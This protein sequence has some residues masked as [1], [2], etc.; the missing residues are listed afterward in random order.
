MAECIIARGSNQQT[1]LSESGAAQIIV[2]PG[3]NTVVYCSNGAN[4]LT[5]ETSGEEVTFN[6]G[7]GSYYLYGNKVKPLSIRVDVEV[8]QIYHVS[9]PGTTYGI[10]ID[11]SIGDPESA[12]TYI[13]DCVGFSPLYCKNTTDGSCDYGS[14]R[15]II[16][17][18]LGVRPCLFKDGKVVGYLNPDDYTKFENGNS[19]GITNRN[20]GQVMVE[21]VK[22]WYKWSIDGDVLSF[23]ISDYDRTSEGF[24]CDAFLSED[25]N[26]EIKDHFYMAAYPSYEYSGKFYSYSGVM[27]PASGDNKYNYTQLF[28]CIPTGYV[29]QSFYKTMYIGALLT[30]VCRTRNLQQAIGLGQYCYP[31]GYS[32]GQCDKNGLFY[33]KTD[34]NSPIKVFGME[35][36]WYNHRQTVTGILRK[37]N[38]IYM[39]KKCAPYSETGVGYTTYDLSNYIGYVPTKYVPYDNGSIILPETGQSDTNIG[40]CDV[41]QGISGETEDQNIMSLFGAND[42]SDGE[43]GPFTHYFPSWSDINNKVWYY[44]ARL[45]YA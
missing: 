24:S 36:Y 7:F 15:D 19:S 30:L 5:K 27:I 23:E 13:D 39:V 41:F 26:A 20:N 3:G 11:Q 22:R 8:I 6:V 18:W 21:F 33:G 12:C 10:R 1:S 44:S 31:D 45:C 34:R 25:G 38:K 4:I 16:T 14:W 40:W 32:N 29:P 35:N 9:L 17:N 2:N 28:N 37:R 43:Y 42:V